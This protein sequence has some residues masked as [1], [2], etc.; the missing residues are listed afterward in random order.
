MWESVP[1]AKVMHSEVSSWMQGLSLE[2]APATV[3]YAHRV[4]SLA[5]SAAVKDGRMVRNVAEGVPLPRIVCRPMRFLSHEEVAR[6]AAS[7]DAYG[8]LIDVLAYGGLRWGELAALRV[9][10]VD[11]VRRRLEVVEAVTEVNG[12]VVFGTTKNHQRRSV[13]IPRF[14]A[15]ELA[16]EI[17]GKEPD[18]LVFVSPRGEVLRNTNF[19]PRFFD[20]AA[21][22]AGLAGLTPHELRHTAASL[23]V[24]AGANVKAVQQMLGHASAAMTLDVYA[25]L[26]GDDLDA[27]AERLDEVVI[28]RNADSVRTEQRE[29]RA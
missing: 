29:D 7:C 14:L 22:R 16:G 8:A 23:A 12:E 6:L 4:F 18:D 26:F 13:P 15:N 17:A 2:L 9:K 21:E 5:L 27:V 1:L 19:R 24:A 3:R 11:L 28:R 20:P 25:G 10:R